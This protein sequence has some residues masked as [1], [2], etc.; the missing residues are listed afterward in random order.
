MSEVG[1]GGEESKDRLRTGRGV[2]EG[3]VSG[4]LKNNYKDT[5]VTSVGMKVG[6]YILFHAL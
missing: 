6:L 4:Q 2:L 3:G 1:V 5:H